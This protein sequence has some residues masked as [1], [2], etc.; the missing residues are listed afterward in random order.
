VP[1]SSD[2]HRDLL[3]GQ[4]HSESDHHHHPS[5]LF[6]DESHLTNEKSNG[7]QPDLTLASDVDDEED[8]DD[9]NDC[10]VTEFPWQSAALDV[11]S[12]RGHSETIESEENFV[13]R[14][15]C[16]PDL[17]D[18]V[19]GEMGGPSKDG[20]SKSLPIHVES[21]RKLGRHVYHKTQY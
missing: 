19:R 17:E 5:R 16:I 12:T 14:R 10:D 1:L 3:A 11:S 4:Y 8:D 6:F 13:S 7:N 9:N 18:P 2:I 21:H 20:I 15:L